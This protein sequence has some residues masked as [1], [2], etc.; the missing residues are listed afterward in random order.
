[1]TE[2]I[3]LAGERTELGRAVRNEMARAPV[4][5]ATA[6]LVNL[7]LQP[8]NTLLH[9]GRAWEKLTPA[10]IVSSTR[11]LLASR[12]ARDAGF[13]VHA[14]YAFLRAAEQSRRVGE[15]LRPI[16]EAALEAEAMVLGSGLPACVVRVGYV[17]G[18]ESADLRAY[19]LA[20]RLGRP[21]WAGAKNRLQHHVHS[22]DAAAALL[23][24]AQ[25]GR[26]GKLFYATDAT[27]AS[28]ADFGDYFARQVGNPFPTHIPRVSRVFA[29]A[30]I[31]DEHMEMVEIG[32]R[33]PAEPQVPGFTP[34]YPDY[35][36]GLDA[37]LAE[38]S[39]RKKS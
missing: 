39:R 33:G 36:A 25:N 26:S 18:P 8:P 4:P 12:D 11:T 30:I 15:H 24:A 32:V 14:S 20:F 5:E 7:R 10:R 9:D 6:A 13:L 16:V 38:W 35:R 34:R 31:A 1:L 23:K 17:Y 2:A 37:V 21:Y 19:R 3:Q 29:R 22:A 27:P 28:F